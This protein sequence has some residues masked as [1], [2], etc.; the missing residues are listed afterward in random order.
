M[1]KDKKKK[2]GFFAE[3]KAFISKGNILDL[4]VAVIIGAAFGKIVTSLT[5]DIIMPLVTLAMGKN[6]LADAS[7]V[8]RAAQLDEAGNVLVEA[9]TWNYGNFLQAIIDFLIIAFV[10]FLFIKVVMKIKSVSETAQNKIEEKIAGLTAKKA[11]E[12]AAENGAAE[13]AASATE[14]TPAEENKEN[15]E[16]KADE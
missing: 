13:D 6:S 14:E 4:S 11:A 5:N 2:P 12:K 15:E 16:K 1:A 10:V 3:F 7:V 9:L 8:L